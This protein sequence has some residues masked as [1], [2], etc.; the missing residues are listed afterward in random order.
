MYMNLMTLDII[1]LT[2]KIRKVHYIGKIEYCFKLKIKSNNSV[3][4]KYLLLTPSLINFFFINLLRTLYFIK[5]FY[6]GIYD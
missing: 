1:D 6:K 2:E 3:I 4:N 5:M